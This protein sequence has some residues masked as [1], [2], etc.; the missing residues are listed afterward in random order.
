[1]KTKNYRK[2]A[3]RNT[4]SVKLEILSRKI[5]LYVAKEK[6][7]KN[8]R[9]LEPVTFPPEQNFVHYTTTTLRRFFFM[10]VLFQQVFFVLF[11]LKKKNEQGKKK[12]TKTKN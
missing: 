10:Y 1:M 9:R 8:R 4:L 12:N 5:D 2:K 6:T 11:F 3:F 7:R